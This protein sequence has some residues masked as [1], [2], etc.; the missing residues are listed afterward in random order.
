MIYK[1]FI[2]PIIVTLITQVIKNLISMGKG[3]FNWKVLLSYGGMPST[4]SAL[5]TSLVV[6]IGK[7][8]GINSAAFAV[9]LIVALITL[10]DAS[11][12]RW[13]LGEY[14]KTINELIKEL[15][16]DK[17]YKY[18]VLIEKFGHKNIEV[19]AGILVSLILTSLI[20]YIL[21]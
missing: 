18:P 10:K 15:P 14:G 9:S 7:Y 19:L 12:I 1:L 8:E 13:H 5:V 3:E 20:I 6:V 2:I 21:N 11:G 16:D 17:E 4:H